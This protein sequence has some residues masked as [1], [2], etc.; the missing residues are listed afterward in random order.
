[1]A[2]LGTIGQ[3]GGNTAFLQGQIV[4]NY[5]RTVVLGSREAMMGTPSEAIMRCGRDDTV[6]NPTPPSQKVGHAFVLKG[7]YVPVTAGS[8]QIL[9]DVLQDVDPGTGLRPRMTVKANPDVGLNTD[10][11]VDAAVGVAWQTLTAAFTATGSGAVEVWR[12]KRYQGMADSIWWDN[13]R[14]I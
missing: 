13:L 3:N 11:V 6:G 10:L 2:D 8:R 4:V 12:E 14:I 9:I 1:M 7:L 5:F